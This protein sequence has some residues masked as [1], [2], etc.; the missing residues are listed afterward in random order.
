[1]KAIKRI[2]SVVL[3]LI[4]CFGFAATSVADTLLSTQQAALSKIAPEI[5]Q[6]FEDGAKKVP[7]YIWLTDINQASVEKEVEQKTGLTRDTLSVNTE[8]ISAELAMAI[9]SESTRGFSEKTTTEFNSYLERTAQARELERINTDT[10]IS[11]RR[12]IARSKIESKNTA[13]VTSAEISEK[14]I[15]FQS[16]YAPMIIAELSE[17]QVQMMAGRLDVAT[18]TMYEAGQKTKN[19][20]DLK[21]QVWRDN[22]GVSMVRN[23]FGLTGAG[24]K[25][26]IIELA[27]VEPNTDDLPAER[28]IA[29]EEFDEYEEDNSKHAERV[30][31]LY[32]GKYGVAKDATVYCVALEGLESYESQI[33]K[34]LERNVTVINSSVGKDYEY[35]I[36]PY[37]NTEKYIDYIVNNHNVVIVQVA[38]NDFAQRITCP[39]N[40]YNVIT[41]GGFNNRSTV[42]IEDD[43][44]CAF[45]YNEYGGCMKPDVIA[46]AI[47]PWENTISPYDGHEAGTSYA[48]PVVA[49]FIA[50]MMKLKPVLASMPEVVKAIVLASCHRKVAPATVDPDDAEQMA[51]GIT[52][53]QGAGVFDPYIALSII[54]HGTYGGRV[55]AADETEIDVS[56]IQPRYNSSGMNVSIAWI[57]QN[58]KS[59]LS[60]IDTADCE[61]FDIKLWNNANKIGESVDTVSSTEM[62][63]HSFAGVTSDLYTLEIKK[64]QGNGNATRIGYAWSVSNSCKQNGKNGEGIYL[65]RN[66]ATGNYLQTN[67]ATGVVHQD[68]LFGN[69]SQIWLVTQNAIDN[70]FPDMFWNIQNGTNINGYLSYISSNENGYLVSTS[71]NAT[72]VIGLPYSGNVHYFMTSIENQS[73]VL[74]ISSD[75][76]LTSVKWIPISD[77]EELTDYQLWYMEPC[78]YQLYDAN[79]NGSISAAD[80]RFLLRCS[81]GLETAN[82]VQ[83]YLGDINKDNVISAADARSALRRSVGLD[84]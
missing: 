5:T 63:Y 79:M 57:R 25:I 64:Y 73:C 58:T 33:E 82:A 60:I 30:A 67:V 59:I 13:F 9:T 1:M 72:T 19:N 28:F 83:R 41:V 6:A 11:E 21:M 37:Y 81:V 46:P 61:D 38:G 7:V 29:V 4:F 3:S 35:Y 8:T 48:A 84:D 40:A 66:V 80:A 32:A 15:I 23:T 39:G 10:Y 42:A 20:D 18:M 16:A 53:K 49:G 75:S 70:Y 56:F 26:G 47:G 51:W 2:T 14:S 55:M 22:V 71:D 31:K 69:L 74:G 50:L 43:I 17:Y 54:S 45:S 27:L 78:A 76:E 77:D 36:S 62:I 34:L 68:A 52:D 12:A 65:L 24:V 44:M